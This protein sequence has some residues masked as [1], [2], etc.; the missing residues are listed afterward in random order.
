MSHN[1]CARQP[2][3]SHRGTLAKIEIKRRVEENKMK[4]RRRRGE[5]SA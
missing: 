1:H 2:V 5:A 3:S 4:A